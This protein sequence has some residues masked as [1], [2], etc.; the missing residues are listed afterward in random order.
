MVSVLF[1]IG[2]VI[3]AMVFGLIVMAGLYIL[4]N[5]LND[6]RRK[7]MMPKDKETLKDGGPMTIDT[8]EVEENE[9]KRIRK[10]REFEK[11][12]RKHIIKDKKARTDSRREDRIRELQG[13]QYFK[14]QESSEE[15]KDESTGEDNSK[16]GQNRKRIKIIRPTTGADE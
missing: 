14:G 3:G 1:F 2:W 13:G 8:K 9:R 15:N 16:S 11:L 10:F 7:L 5:F 6:K 4:F 12:R